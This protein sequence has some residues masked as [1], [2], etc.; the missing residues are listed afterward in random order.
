[1]DDPVGCASGLVQE[2]TFIRRPAALMRINASCAER[3]PEVRVVGTFPATLSTSRPPPPGP[4]DQAGRTGLRLAAV[5][6]AAVSDAVWRWYYGD[7]VKGWGLRGE[8]LQLPGTA[9]ASGS[10]S[11]GCAGRQ[12]PGSAGSC[13]WNQVSGQVWAQLTE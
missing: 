8:R 3:T 5:G 11:P 10:G 4:G 9:A 7:G 1:M 6:A 13:G 12:T 2:K